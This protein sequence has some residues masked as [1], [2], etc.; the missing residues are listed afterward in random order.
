MD[1]VGIFNAIQSHAMTLGLFETVCGHETVNAPGHGLHYEIWAGPIG[2][3]RGGSGLD[4]TSASVTIQGRVKVNTTRDPRDLV[5]TDLLYAVDRL[6]S[7]YTA[8]FQLGLPGVR[9][10]DVHGAYGLALS[11]RPGYI[12]Q[13]GDLFRV[14]D[15]TIPIICNDVWEQLP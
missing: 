10:I 1:V 3:I 9:N 12:S 2:P 11:A 5:E 6:I 14:A 4:I 7:E 8:N 15:I 13:S